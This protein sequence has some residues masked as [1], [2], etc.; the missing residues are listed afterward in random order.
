MSD[1]DIEILKRK[2]SFLEQA[3]MALAQETGTHEVQTEIKDLL[4]ADTE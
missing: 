4:T 3:L 2:V 1:V